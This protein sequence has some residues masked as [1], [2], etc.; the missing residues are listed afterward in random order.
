MLTDKYRYLGCTLNE[1]LDFKVTAR[2]QAAGSSR[3]LG[4]LSKF[5]LNKGLGCETYKKLYNSC[6]VPIMDY[7][8]AIW[9]FNDNDNINKVHHRAMRNFLGVY[10][11]APTAGVEGDLGWVRPLIRR[12]I[13]ILRFWNRIV[14][15]DES[16]L[17]CQIYNE[18]FLKGHPWISNVKEI[19]DSINAT[20]TFENNVPIVNFKQFS[21]F[22]NN[23][24]MNIYIADIWSETIRSKPKVDLYRQHKLYMKE[25]NYCK[26]M[27]KHNQRSLIARLRLGIFPINLELGRYKNIC[28]PRM[29]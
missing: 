8:S 27:L 23:M 6:I 4:K 18:M 13:E 17:P 3:A 16:R 5:Y 21:I 9:G 12:K 14:S 11:Y 24:L 29:P 19:F 28:M 25:E 1:Y 26:V 2:T 20:D 22:V 10:K 15:L 7:G